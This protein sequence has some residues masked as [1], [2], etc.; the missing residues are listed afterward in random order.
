MSLLPELQT[1]TAEQTSEQ[2]ATE[3]LHSQTSTDVNECVEANDSLSYRGC[4]SVMV[5]WKQ[6]EQAAF[7][8]MSLVK[9]LLVGGA[10][11]GWICV[12][13]KDTQ[14]SCTTRKSLRLVMVFSSLNC[15]IR[16]R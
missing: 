12:S 9:P 16:V 15:T 7:S 5:C 6:L 13:R 10:E 14:K 11:R 4:D 3:L 2:V 8:F 1:C